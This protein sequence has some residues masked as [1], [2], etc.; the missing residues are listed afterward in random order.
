M[1]SKYAGSAHAITEQLKPVHG[2][3]GT[4]DRRV[5]VENFATN[6]GRIL[7]NQRKE[8]MNE[9]TRSFARA[10]IQQLRV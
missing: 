1:N 4:A 8:E 10:I 5:M 3:D 2:S 6:I 9:E 7:K